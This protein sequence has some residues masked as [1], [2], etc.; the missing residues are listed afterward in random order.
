MKIDNAHLQAPGVR[1][2]GDT[3][4]NST[5]RSKDVAAAG[6]DAGSGAAK[7]AVTLS[8]Q[9]KVVA[10][11]LARAGDLDD[12]RPDVVARAK[13]ALARGEVGADLERLAD[14]MIDDL[15]D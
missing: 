6:I 13:A 4:A 14:R 5:T 10:G 7:D 15:L 8:D 9:A 3:A 1:V 2:Q 12:V 11:A